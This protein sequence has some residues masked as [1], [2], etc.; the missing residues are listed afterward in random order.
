MKLV[1][2]ADRLN[3]GYHVLRNHLPDSLL[4]LWRTQL[5]VPRS[6]LAFNVGGLLPSG[7]L[8][9]EVLRMVAGISAAR[10]V[11]TPFRRMR[12]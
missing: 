4:G 2:E 1:L 5:V 9:G 10:T 11:P 8:A 7:P 12:R 6:V 3:V